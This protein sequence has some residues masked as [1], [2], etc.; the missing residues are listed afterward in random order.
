MLMN[1]GR[2]RLWFAVVAV[3]A[4]SGAAS[5]RAF[6]RTHTA[7][8]ESS[9]CPSQCTNLGVPLAWGESE[10]SY[11]FNERGFPGVPDAQL[12]STFGAAFA[13]WEAVHCDGQPVGFTLVQEA[14]T[15]ALDEGPMLDEPNTNA[16]VHYDALT[17]LERDHSPHAFAVTSVWFAKSGRIYGAD[18]SF[19][20]GMGPYGDCNAT[21]CGAAGGPR[22]DLQNVATHEV[23]HFFG[24]AHSEVEDSTMACEANAGEVMK[25]SL[26]A[27]DSAGLCAVYPPGIA[28]PPEP[29]QAGGACT[30]SASSQGSALALLMLAW[31]GRRRRQ[32][33]T[34]STRKP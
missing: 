6:C 10:I 26:E 19:N 2:P 7:D 16:V 14:E 31:L 30:L 17:W 12:R 25:R 9:R 11:A 3:L 21:T 33:V 32:R 4:A 23:G 18:I 8:P 1:G 15:T 24:L 28:F 29:K 13:S 22:T 5:A 34:P 27:D 20:G